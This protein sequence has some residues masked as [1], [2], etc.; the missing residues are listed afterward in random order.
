MS[1]RPTFDVCIVNSQTGSVEKRLTGAACHRHAEKI[2]RGVNINLDHAKF[3]TEIRKGLT[4]NVE[5]QN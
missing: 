5:C 4:K 2:Q 1:D 3:H